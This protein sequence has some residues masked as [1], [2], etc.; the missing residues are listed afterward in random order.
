MLERK[1]LLSALNNRT[2]FERDPLKV[3]QIGL[4]KS[5]TQKHK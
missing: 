1:V 5:V 4:T 2:I 3:R